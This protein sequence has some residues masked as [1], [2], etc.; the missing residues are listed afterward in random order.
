[1]DLEPISLG[2]GKVGTRRV[3]LPKLRCFCLPSEEITKAKGSLATHT[4]MHTCT[5]PRPGGNHSEWLSL[6]PKERVSQGLLPQ[7]EGSGDGGTL[8][9]LPFS[10]HLPNMLKSRRPVAVASLF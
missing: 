5:S 9:H 4:L 7:G 10:V 1:M 6:L 2:W 8:P 3:M